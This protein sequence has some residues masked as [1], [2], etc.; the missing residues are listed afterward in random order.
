MIHTILI[1]IFYL[2]KTIWTQLKYK[3]WNILRLGARHVT[4]RDAPSSRDLE[5]IEHIEHDW[6]PSSNWMFYALLDLE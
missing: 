2:Y 5:H 6:W 4:G 1:I 3:I